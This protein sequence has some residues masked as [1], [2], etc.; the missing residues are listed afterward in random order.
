MENNLKLLIEDE[1]LRGATEIKDKELDPRCDGVTMYSIQFWKV[2]KDLID[3]DDII[4]ADMLFDEKEWHRLV[5]IDRYGRRFYFYG[6]SSGY[7]GE[8]PRGA[9][10]I[11]SEAGFN[12]QDIKLVYEEEEFT[13]Y[14]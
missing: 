9:A 6:V 13:I 10:K 8:G 14:K 2:L 7:G 1:L 5:L 12:D 4:R 11:L 3:I